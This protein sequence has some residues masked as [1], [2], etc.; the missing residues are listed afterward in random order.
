MR[1]RRKLGALSERRQCNIALGLEFGPQGWPW[2]TDPDAEIHEQAENWVRY[3]GDLERRGW[4]FEPSTSFWAAI[5][6]G[7]A[8]EYFGMTE[9]RALRMGAVHEDGTR[10]TDEELIAGAQRERAEFDELVEKCRRALAS[11]HATA[12]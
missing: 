2:V 1:S 6:A 5:A 3:R 9:E 8:P 11:L 7:G 10:L 4:T 12:R